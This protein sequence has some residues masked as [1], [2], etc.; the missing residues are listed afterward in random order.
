VREQHRDEGVLLVGFGSYSGSVMAGSSWGAPMQKMKVPKGI[1][2]SLERQLHKSDPANKLIIFDE[3]PELKEAFA[4]RI[5][6][7]AIGVVYDPGWERGNYVPSKMSDRYD[8]FLFIDKTEALHP[9][10]IKPKG[11][12]TP[13]TYPFGI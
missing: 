6:H 8:A 7:R 13:E 9:L 2:G 1:E 12:L 4:E 5:G 11:D 3:G 10:K